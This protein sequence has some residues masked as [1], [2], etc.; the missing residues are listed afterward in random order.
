MRV[1]AASVVIATGSAPVIP[2]VLLGLGDRLVVNDDV[3]SWNT[4]PKSVAVVGAGVIGLELGQ[5]L[6]RLGVKVSVLGSH[7]RVGPLTDPAIIAE[8]KNRLAT[9]FHLEPQGSVVSAIR[10]GSGVLLRYRRTDGSLHEGC[11]EYVLA[12]CGRQPNVTRIGLKN[13][14]IETDARGVPHFDAQTLQAGAL[15]V[16]MAGDVN[17]K[18]QILHEAADEGRVAG[19]NA[20]RLAKNGEATSLVR[21]AP[22]AVVFTDPQ[23]ALVGQRFGDLPGGS[24]V[25][26]EVSFV[27]QGRSRVMLNNRG[28]L[29]VYAERGSGRFL[30]AEMMAPAAEHLGHLLAWSLQMN[31]TIDAMLAMPFYHPVVEEGVRTA[32]R[33]AAKNL[34]RTD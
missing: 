29:R 19:R 15:P 5:A 7:G 11:Y 6:A 26:G 20:A 14:S 17:G 2:D 34:G 22:L 18:L 23:M 25:V 24:F 33:D 27:D 12:A 13:T 9:E 28:R 1:H 21:R 8:A 4:L 10:I 32:L 3:F 30:G 31:L 16:F